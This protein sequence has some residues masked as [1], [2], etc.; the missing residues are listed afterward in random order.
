MKPKP[1]LLL[2]L[3]FS[4]SATAFA[5]ESNLAGSLK[6]KVI[7][8]ETKQP[9][10][11]VNIYI[12]ELKTGCSTDLEGEYSLPK[13]KIG[14]YNLVFSYVGHEKITIPDVIVRSARITYTN[15]ELRP[16]DINLAAVE[17]K[18]G[19]FSRTESQNISA[20]S[21]SF[22]EIRR[23]PG[24]GGDVSRIIF[25]L[26]SLAKV[27]DTK[28]SLIVRGGSPVENGFYIDNIEIS[29]I[30]H[31]PV[32]GSSEGPI[33]IINVDLIENVNFLSGGFNSSYGDRLS[34]I[35]ELKYR[36][37]NRTTTDVQ[38]DMSMQGF[39]GVVEGPLASGKGSYVISAR[40]SY[41]DLILDLMNEKVGMPVYA[42][43][44]G[45]LVYDLSDKHQISVIDVFSH[46]NQLMNQE[47]AIDNKNYVYSDYLYNTNT[48]GFNWQYL[49]G[50]SGY[51]NTSLSHTFRK[52]DGKFFQTRDAKLLVNNKTLEQ[53]VNFRNI[54]HWIAGKNIK[55]EF[56]VDAKY[57][58]NKYNQYY[59]E[60]KD[61]LGQTTPA[62]TMDK[63]LNTFRAGSFANLI[64]K[65]FENVT[66][67][68]SARVDY[69]D[70]NK[71]TNI[72]PRVS[73]ALSLDDATIVTG[74]FGVYYQGIPLVLAAQKDEFKSLKNPKTYQ[75]IIGITRMLEESTRLTLE[76]YNKSYYDFPV[77]PTQPNLFLFDQAAMENLFLPHQ[78]LLSKGRAN[79]KGVE[80]TIQKKLAKD[81]YGLLSGSYSK[82]TYEGYNGIKYDRIYDNRFNFA[83]EGGYKPNESWEF[84]LRWL[85]AGGAPYTPFNEAAS[86]A[87]Y[88]GILDESKTNSSRLPDFHS[89]NIRADKRFHFQSSTLI[90]Y[91]S[92]WNAYA[93]ENI[94]AYT[95]NEIDNKPD[96]E[97]MWG[98]LP[99]F[100]IEF[101][102]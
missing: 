5:Q 17:V 58:T 3:L 68:P 41:L 49:W 26:P 51:S 19:Y 98:L 63:T 16:T 93:R 22:E 77:D 48:L 79:S 18:A 81:F 84:S 45:K 32:Q 10:I 101:E 97:K 90:V 38:L 14:S 72:S 87:A 62:L 64:L 31:F 80:L 78:Q 30:N 25:G 91:L 36:E 12:P 1:L 20:T 35:M 95:W 23:A 76:F 67:T 102:F 29:N 34:S 2:I 86:R 4:I 40:R 11:G 57:I 88:K 73:L 71:T 15:A 39:G 7:D 75:S 96:K 50:S 43:V 42:D 37:G 28:N 82:A 44:Q 46:D 27:N 53:E 59:N 85:Y 89:L 55:L 56:G 94:A 6:G 24:A 65:P 92:V 47:D 74:S 70:F 61:L 99:I 69:Y 52:T 100:G 21:F 9:L 33:G 60:Y 8:L 83:I 13:V 54:N 66:F